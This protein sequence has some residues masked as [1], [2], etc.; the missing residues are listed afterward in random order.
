MTLL[1][2][3]TQFAD[4]RESKISYS[5]VINNNISKLR[6]HCPE[7]T[8][9]GN[10]L[11]AKFAVHTISALGHTWKHHF[12]SILKPVK[13]LTTDHSSIDTSQSDAQK[14]ICFYQ[15]VFPGL[16]TAGFLQS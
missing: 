16:S 11:W 3:P 13:M 14:H 1:P 2:S 4:L 15:S 10:F 12:L 5:T 9:L 8:Q 6:L 7:R